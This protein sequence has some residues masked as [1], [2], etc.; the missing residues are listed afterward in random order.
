MS[1]A[2]VRLCSVNLGRAERITHGRHDFPSGICKRPCSGAVHIARNGVAG[3]VIVDVQHHGGTDQAVYVYRSE[4][5]DWWTEQLGQALPPGAFGENLTI[6]G[7]PA[8]MHVGDRLTIG[9]A[10]LE[11]TAPRIPCGTLAARMQDSEFGMA[12]R[13]AERPGAYCRVLHEGTV[14]AGDAVTLRSNP[15]STVS[16]VQLFRLHYALKADAAELQAALQA[17]LAERFRRNF[18]RKLAAA[19]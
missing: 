1:D 3:D 4:D 15:A 14:C 12:F 11:A 2:A 13:R 17:P 10:L 16:I 9:A 19:V 6:V 7:L 18:A 8:D 5:Y